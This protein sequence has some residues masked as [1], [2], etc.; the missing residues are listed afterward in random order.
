LPPD[1]VIWRYSKKQIEEIFKQIQNREIDEIN[2]RYKMLRASRSQ[3]NSD[4]FL[5]KDN[6]KKIKENKSLS[7]VGVASDTEL[8]NHNPNLKIRR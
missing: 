8:K 4:E 6:N 3:D 1:E 5:T 2:L 7:N